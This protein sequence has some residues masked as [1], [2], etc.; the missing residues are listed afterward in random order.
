M[1]RYSPKRKEAALS[2]MLPPQSRTVSEVASEEDIPYNTLYTWLK[3]AQ[4]H[5]VKM[6]TSQTWTAESKL[7]V[8]IETGTL[9]SSELACYCRENGLY[10]EQ[11][12]TWKEEFV[13]SVQPNKIKDKASIKEAQADKK[14]IKSLKKELRR[15]EKA[16]AET[17]AL[18]VLRKKFNALYDLDDEES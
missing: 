7:A 13:Q 3:T 2:K 12:K 15:K 18:L 1:V 11:I 4:Q 6:T 9:T 5:G 17:A 10:P 8:I 14:E 16:L